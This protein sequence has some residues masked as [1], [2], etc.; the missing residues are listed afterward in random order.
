MRHLQVAGAVFCISHAVAFNPVF[1]KTLAHRSNFN[2]LHS[3]SKGNGEKHDGSGG[4][5]EG[6][7]LQTTVPIMTLGAIISIVTLGVPEFAAAADYEWAG[8]VRL[9]S[10]PLLQ[11]SQF[12]MLLR[13]ILSWYPEINLNKMP[14]L[15]LYF[16]TEPILRATRSVVPPAF[17]VDVSPVVWIAVLSF[18]REILFGQQGLFNMLT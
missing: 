16:V 6:G 12:A 11:L 9:V 15:L 17:G 2:Q 5:I 1:P 10:D 4:I 8:P 7:R 13:V 3:V 18:F 14:Y